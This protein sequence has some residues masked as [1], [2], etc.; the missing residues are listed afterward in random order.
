MRLTAQDTWL[1]ATD[2]ENL[3]REARW[4]EAAPAQAK[5]APVPGII[6]EVFRDYH[7]VAWYW[8]TVIGPRNPYAGGRTLLRFGAVDYLSEVWLNGQYLGR[9][10]GAETPF[11]LDATDALRPGEPNLLAVRVLNPTR[12][13]IEGIVLKE[14]P[15]RNKGIPFNVGGSYNHGGIMEPV[16]VLTT[17]A[18]YLTD[19][20]VQPDF[21]TGQVAIYWTVLNTSPSVRPMTINLLVTEAGGGTPVDSVTLPQSGAPGEQVVE[22]HL[23]VPGPRPWELA[24][25]YLYRV[26]ARLHLDNAVDVYHEASTRFGFRDFRIADGY[27]RLNGRRL[28]LRCSHT[29]NHFPV[30]MQVPHDPD[31]W[32]RDLLNVKAMGFNAIRFIAGVPTPAQ[33]DCCD[34]IGLLVYEENYAS[35]CMVD[36]PHYGERYARSFRGMIQRDRNHPSVVIWGLLNESGGQVFQ[37]AVEA[38]PFI[39]ALDETRLVMLNSGRF[40]GQR[41]IGSF[42]NPGSHTWEYGL[43][44]EG[45]EQGTALPVALQ[46]CGLMEGMGDV[47]M[48]PF[49]PHAPEVNTLLRTLG[50]EG[51]AVFLSEY[52]IG[53]AVDLMRVVKLYEQI[54][55]G[56]SIDARIYRGYRD[57]FLAD[58]ARW[59]MAEALGRPEDYFRQALARMAKDRLSGLNCIRSNPHLIGY[60]LTGT[61]DQG[62]TGEGLCTTFR[63]LK[64][65]TMEAMADGLAPLRWCLFTEPL[66]LYRG[67]A[68]HVEAVLANED[69]LEPGA[70]PVRFAIFDPQQKVVWERTT[71]VVIPDEA[72]DTLPLALP[73]LDEQVACEGPAGR[74]RFTA[75]MVDGAAPA[76]EVVGF[77]V[78]DPADLPAVS[79]AVTLWSDDPEVAQWLTDHGIAC[80]PFD[81]SCDERCLILVSDRPAPAATAAEFVELACHVMRGSTV[82]ILSPAAFANQDKPAGWFPWQEDIVWKALPSD[83]YNKDEW[84]K[85]HPVFAGLPTGMLDEYFYRDLI[86]FEGWEGSDTLWEAIAGANRCALHPSGY[87]S[88]LL[89]SRHRAGAGQLFLNT[90][91]L[92]EGLGLH[93]AADRLLLNLLDYAWATLERGE[94]LAALPDTYIEHLYTTVYPA[95]RQSDWLRAM[96]LSEPFADSV[97]IAE[98]TLPAGIAFPRRPLNDVRCPEGFIS[99]ERLDEGRPGLVYARGEFSVPVAMACAVLV[100]TD[101][102]IKV[103]IDDEVIGMVA[104]ASNPAQLDAHRF[105]VNLSSGR[106]VMTVAFSRREGKAWGF[107]LR[108]LR[109]DETLTPAEIRAGQARVPLEAATLQDA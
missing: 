35:W 81:P 29:G 51:Q 58:W 54:G 82:V 6:Q 95:T 84:A 26:T 23:T 28:F 27:F 12:E 73:V 46:G 49:V 18:A 16:E 61:V 71:T 8:H 78:A 68:M 62:M 76:G 108:F 45:P 104:E 41:Q 48:Y 32:R 99:L 80:H 96:H 69:V 11:T 43:G 5:P 77:D 88:G 24:D 9:H 106:H 55:Q 72:G 87:S 97:P 38:L 14:T 20:Y 15:H 36:S 75:T 66:N 105:A 33:L 47:H 2:P 85:P 52:G 31:F 74:Y 19:L 94:P 25:P 1:L 67:A 101:G 65:G 59:R 13:P 64:P 63:E 100:G 22:A 3:G 53:S 86:P 42:S 83:L 57:R 60:S 90:F 34:E 7:G 109:T 56:D 44:R 50:A 39:R 89:L 93:P 10:E 107:A 70:Y 98:V 37:Y 40:D 79:A 103:W 17:P 30:G 21:A 102:P 91:R 4:W 92:R